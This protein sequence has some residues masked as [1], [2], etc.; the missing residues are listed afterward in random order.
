MCPVRMRDDYW[1]EC[2]VTSVDLMV[3]T[4]I[5]ISGESDSSGFVYGKNFLYV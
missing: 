4:D 5:L 1:N 3:V 2:R